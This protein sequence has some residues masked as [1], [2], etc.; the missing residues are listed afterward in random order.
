[1]PPHCIDTPIHSLH[2]HPE[3][4][5]VDKHKKGFSDKKLVF[6]KKLLKEKHRNSAITHLIFIFHL[7]FL[8]ALTVL[9][10][11]LGIGGC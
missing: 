11:M 10:K 8:L 5:L 2:D 4:S 9:Y 7:F 1:V 3:T 6:S